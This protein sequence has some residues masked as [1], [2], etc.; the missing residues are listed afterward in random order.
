MIHIAGGLDLHADEHLVIALTFS[1]RNGASSDGAERN[2]A[3]QI[4]LMYSAR[5]GASAGFAARAVA[6]AKNTGG[7]RRRIQAKSQASEKKHRGSLLTRRRRFGDPVRIDRD[8]STGRR[9]SGNKFVLLY[10][11]SAKR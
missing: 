10:P 5:D 1:E 11:C 6:V 3:E 8:R 2:A 9:Y 7:D 4:A